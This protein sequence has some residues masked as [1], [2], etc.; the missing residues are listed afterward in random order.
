MLHLT[1]N[2][3][4]EVTGDTARAASSWIVAQNSKRGPVVDC[5]GNYIDS[6]QKVGTQWLFAYRKIDRF[7]AADLHPALPSK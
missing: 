2:V 1:S 4:I 6:L 5:A 7:I 3:I